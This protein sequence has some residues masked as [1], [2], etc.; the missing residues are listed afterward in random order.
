MRPPLA[1]H[2]YGEIKIEKNEGVCKT[3]KPREGRAH[4]VAGRPADG[5]AKLSKYSFSLGPACN[6]PKCYLKSVNQVSQEDVGH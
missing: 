4:M 3:P 5:S 6:H 1:D 2:S